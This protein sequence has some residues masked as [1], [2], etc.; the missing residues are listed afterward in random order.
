MNGYAM[1]HAEVCSEAVHLPVN[2]GST[3]PEACYRQACE[4]LYQTSAILDDLESSHPGLAQKNEQLKNLIH[5]AQDLFEQ[6][7][8]RLFK[9]KSLK[10]IGLAETPGCRSIPLNPIQQSH[11][12]ELQQ[13]IE[14]AEKGLTKEDKGS[15]WG[16]FIHHRNRIP[17]GRARMT[18][19][20]GY[21]MRMYQLFREVQNPS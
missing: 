12:E 7:H 21:L 10:W 6:A 13:G 2:N 16:S 1:N 8:R 19:E 9:V 3:T 20:I 5:E 4:L 18:F 14:A 11:F 15:P 17:P